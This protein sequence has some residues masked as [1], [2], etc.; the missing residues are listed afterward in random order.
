MF[1][2]SSSTSVRDDPKYYSVFVGSD[3]PNRGDKYLISTMI[4]HEHYSN[5]KWNCIENDIGLIRIRESFIFSPNV[6]PIKL[7][8]IR[9]SIEETAWITGYGTYETGIVSFSTSF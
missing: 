8:L 7:A 9:P 2:P 3:T 4:A 6:Q 5:S 1:P